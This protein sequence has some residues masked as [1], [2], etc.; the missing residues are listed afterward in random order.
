[1]KRSLFLLCWVFLGVGL[2]PFYAI[3]LSS[4]ILVFCLIWALS[5]IIHYKKVEVP[6]VL[7][8]ILLF[9]SAI[10]IWS[11]Y[12][13]FRSVEAASGLFALLAA[14]KLYEIKSTRDYFLF[15]LIYQ[16]MMISQY[17]LLESL[18]LLAFMIIAT[19]LM[20]GVFMD[21][22]RDKHSLESFLSKPKRQVLFKVM[23]YSLILSIAL[24]FVFPRTNF[25]LFR[26]QTSQGVNPWTGFSNE[27]R[28]GSISEIIL[29]DQN[30]FRARFENEA[31]PMPEM[32]WQGGTLSNT[33]G[34]NWSKDTRLRYTGFSSSEELGRYQYV[35]DM[36]EVGGGSI[37]LLAPATSFKLLT[38]GQTNRRG[39]GD[40]SVTPLSTQKLRWSGSSDSSPK[41]TILNQS[42]KQELNVPLEIK[43]FILATYPQF[44]GL[45]LER[46]QK[47]LYL[48][49]SRDF[50]YTLNPGVYDGSPLDQLREF[51][52][53]R[54]RGVCEHYASAMAVIL[55]SFGF[56]AH[57]MVGFQ[58]G[59]YNQVGDYWLIRGRDAHAWV[60]ASD[61]N[62]NWRRYDP[63]AYVVPDRLI[64]GATEFGFNQEQLVQGSQEWLRILRSGLLN[65]VL[66]VVDSTFYSLNLAFINYDATT[67]Q[68]FLSSLGLHQWKRS[69]LK[70]ASG[71]IA[72][73]AIAL[74][75]LYS[76]YNGSDPWAPVNKRYQTF[77]KKLHILDLNVPTSMPPYQ[78]LETL[79]ARGFGAACLDFIQIYIN[80]KYARS[81]ATP[82]KVDVKRLK[83]QLTDALTEIKGMK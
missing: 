82:R 79:R 5:L 48:L 37:F 16:L 55:R 51:L 50:S 58:G 70:W 68:E 62:G 26:N 21:L 80:I 47:E 31:A 23:G 59:D 30:V 69:W 11:E 40:A 42:F 78:L 19:S 18:F 24:F 20:C 76:R 27:L 14:L 65:D 61:G 9:S 36:A 73:L 45:S 74:Y 83:L 72:L 71:F 60:M 17:L 2:L 52:I 56:P 10:F 12:N 43:E 15:F 53:N 25:T 7:R 6:K 49:F 29:S 13:G 75:W 38:L 32:Y 41:T 64:F 28:P 57:V 77:I 66:K 44:N 8:G 46:L 34:F 22:Q 67:Q 35:A 54:K 33:D 63:T 39:L 4:L 3:H 81:D 1:M